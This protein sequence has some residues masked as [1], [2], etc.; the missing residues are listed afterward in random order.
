MEAAHMMENYPKLEPSCLGSSP[1]S[2]TFSLC[3]VLQADWLSV[4]CFPH[5]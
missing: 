3:V 4:I 1:A 2:A 5:L